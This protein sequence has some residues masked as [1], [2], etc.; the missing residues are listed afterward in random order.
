MK[1]M[2]KLEEVVRNEKEVKECK[3]GRGDAFVIG[4]VSQIMF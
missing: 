4:I 3:G 1:K 2:V